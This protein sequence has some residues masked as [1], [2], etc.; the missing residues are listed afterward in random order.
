MGYGLVVALAQVFLQQLEGFH[1]VHV[2]LEPLLEG[3]TREDFLLLTGKQ[4]RR[5]EVDDI[6]RGEAAEVGVRFSR[7]RVSPKLVRSMGEVTA[8]PLTERKKA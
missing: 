1:T 6:T 3:I 8:V 5:S 4:Q 7:I 2:H